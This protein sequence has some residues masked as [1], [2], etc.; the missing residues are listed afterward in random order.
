[1][2][3]SK[4]MAAA[5]VAVLAGSMAL[6]YAAQPVSPQGGTYS[7]QADQVEYDMKTGDGTLTGKTT[8]KHDGRVTVSQQGGTFNAKTKSGH[9]TGGVVSTKDDEKLGA[10]FFF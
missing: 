2:K 4:V 10:F 3:R 9:L 7:V 1:M 8:I 6:A 5:L